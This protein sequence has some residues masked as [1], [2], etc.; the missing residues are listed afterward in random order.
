MT[1][2][3]YSPL[4]TYTHSLLLHSWA[5]RLNRARRCAAGFAQPW[6]TQTAFPRIST[7]HRPFLSLPITRVHCCSTLCRYRVVRAERRHA[8]ASSATPQASF[9]FCFSAADSA[10]VVAAALPAFRCTHYS[11]AFGPY[12]LLRGELST[13][14]KLILPLLNDATV[15]C[16]V[17]TALLPHRPRS[18]TCQQFAVRGAIA[19]A[20]TSNGYAGRVSS[21]G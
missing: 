1:T 5:W 14:L 6:L 2:A 3:A 15:V 12:Q 19:L 8:H 9:A 13:L 7:C 11:L 16:R 18:A 21:A 4:L 17:A 10:S 20:V